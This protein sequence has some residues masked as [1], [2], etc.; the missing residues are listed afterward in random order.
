LAVLEAALLAERQIVI[1]VIAI[2]L[3]AAISAV[4]ANTVAPKNVV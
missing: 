3:A 2:R 4:A 1:A